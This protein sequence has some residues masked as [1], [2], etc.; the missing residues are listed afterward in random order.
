MN[1]IHN[2]RLG[3]AAQRRSLNLFRPLCLEA[4]E[5]RLALTIFTVTSLSDGPV[6]L[7]DTTVSLRNAIEAAN[8]DVAVFPGSPAGNGADEIRFKS[9]MSGT[10]VLNQGQLG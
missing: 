9:G 10:I 6:E 8:N 1:N 4:L 2:H 7:G 3:F 5:D